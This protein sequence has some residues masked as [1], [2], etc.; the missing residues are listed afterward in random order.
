MITLSSLHNIITLINGNGEL[1]FTVDISLLWGCWHTHPLKIFI[2]IIRIK[3][4]QWSGVLLYVLGNTT[5]FKKSSEHCTVDATQSR[6]SLSRVKQACSVNRAATG[7]TNYMI[8]QHDWSVWSTK[9]GSVTKKCYARSYWHKKRPTCLHNNYS[10]KGGGVEFCW[11]SRVHYD[12]SMLFLLCVLFFNQLNELN[13]IKL[14]ALL[15][16]HGLHATKWIVPPPL[17]ID[18]GSALSLATA[19]QQLAQWLDLFDPIFVVFRHCSCWS[20]IKYRV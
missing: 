2:P 11:V 20:P 19:R 14:N 1:L 10:E 7:V 5:R 17:S 6:H 4:E 8:F 3:L 13:W 18:S 16:L 12:T 9:Q 15:P